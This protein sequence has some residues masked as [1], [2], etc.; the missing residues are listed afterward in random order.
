ML[1]VL[2]VAQAGHLF[3]LTIAVFKFAGQVPCRKVV[4]DWHFSP[5]NAAAVEK[6][7]EGVA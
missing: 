1:Q 2:C 3:G 4:P 5:K 7:A 6:E